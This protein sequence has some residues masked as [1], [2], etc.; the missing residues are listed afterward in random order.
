MFLLLF[1]IARRTPFQAP[2]ANVT[3]TRVKVYVSK[4]DISTDEEALKKE[5][6][7]A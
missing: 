3:A 2:S 5:M 6:R 1:A 4:K 7:R